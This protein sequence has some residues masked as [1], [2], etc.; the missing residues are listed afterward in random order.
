MNTGSAASRAAAARAWEPVLD[1]AGPE[2]LDLG[3]QILAVAHQVAVGSLSAPLTDPGRPGQ[4]KADLAHRLFHGRVDDRVV[5]LLQ[6]LVR[7]RWS[8]P[9]DLISALHDLGI[10]AILTG[11]RSAGTLEQVEQEIFGVSAALE[12]D[13][14]LRRALE[15]SRRSRGRDRVRLA[16]QVFGA[17]LTSSTMSLVVW[18]V[19]HRAEGG[20]PRNLRR[21]AELAARLQDRVVADVV[22]AVPLSEVQ[23]GRLRAL[24]VARL[25]TDVEINATLDPQVIGGLKVVVQDQVIDSTV[26]HRLEAVRSALAG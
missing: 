4:D 19:R 21:V 25:G 14:E 16:Q 10:E 3:E 1:L 6:A 8:A 11:A 20:V 15:P 26:R 18:C 17:H 2:G 13:R 7:G 9:V 5:E 24:L 22:S 23:L 12:H